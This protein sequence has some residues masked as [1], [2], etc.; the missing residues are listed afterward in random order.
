[1][2]CSIGEEP[3]DIESWGWSEPH[4]SIIIARFFTNT[5]VH[6]DRFKL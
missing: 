5:T 4:N 1:M 3:D 2:D 6:K